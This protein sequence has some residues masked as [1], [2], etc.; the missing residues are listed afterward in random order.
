MDNKIWGR[1][2]QA[3]DRLGRSFNEMGDR[4]WKQM[5][6]NPTLSRFFTPDKM[7]GMMGGGVK[8]V[9]GFIPPII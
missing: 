5:A 7:K 2:R 8:G 1:I 4:F 9:A 6:K 3:G